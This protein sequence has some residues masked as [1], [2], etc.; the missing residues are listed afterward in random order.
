VSATDFYKDLEG[1]VGCDFYYQFEIQPLNSSGCTSRVAI[2]NVGTFSETL[3]NYSQGNQPVTQFQLHI[4]AAQLSLINANQGTPLQ[5][6]AAVGN[7]STALAFSTPQTLPAGTALTFAAQP[8]VYYFLTAAI[9]AASSATLT[10]AYTGASNVATIPSSQSPMSPTCAVA[11][12][13]SLVATSA[14]A[15]GLVGPGDSLIFSPQPNVPYSVSSVTTGGISLI[16]PYAGPA[17]AAAYAV[18][19]ETERMQSGVYPYLRTLTWPG[20]PPIAL[21][22]GHGMFYLAPNPEN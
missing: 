12:G 1:V 22:Y 2:Q 10:L 16:T 8:S 18:D 7:G 11:T 19:I 13:S 6:T 20:S 21:P 5:G 3:I 15:V 17:A 14:S 4:T 9:V